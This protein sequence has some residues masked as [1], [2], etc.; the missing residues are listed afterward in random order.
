MICSIHFYHQSLVK[1]D[2]VD[3]K[4][5]YDVLSTEFFS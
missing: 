2:K 3:N 1:T 4:I 5:A